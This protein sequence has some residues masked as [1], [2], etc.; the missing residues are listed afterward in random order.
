MKSLSFNIILFMLSIFLSYAIQCFSQQKFENVLGDI[1]VGENFRIYPS[2][3]TQ[4]EVF[5][6]KSPVDENVLF[7]SCN[8]LNFIPFFISE[9]IYPSSCP[10]W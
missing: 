4:T 1:L 7:S 8:T 2:S 5:I 3:V 10:V 9:G 6:V